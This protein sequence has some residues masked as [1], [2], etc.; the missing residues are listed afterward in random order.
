MDELEKLLRDAM[1]KESLHQLH[2]TDYE[3]NQWT[4]PVLLNEDR[5]N[6]IL[7]DNSINE[8]RLILTVK[9]K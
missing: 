5:I 7:N 1:S 9:L 2:F 6:R 4:V 3:D 8:I